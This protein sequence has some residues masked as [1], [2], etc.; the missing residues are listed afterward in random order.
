M[1]ILCQWDCQGLHHRS[2]QKKGV[3]NTGLAHRWLWDRL[4]IRLVKCFSHAAERQVLWESCRKC[5]HLPAWLTLCCTLKVIRSD[6]PCSLLCVSCP[7]VAPEWHA[8]VILNPADTVWFCWMYEGGEKVSVQ[9]V[10]GAQEVP[11]MSSFCF[12]VGGN[13]LDFDARKGNGRRQKGR[14]KTDGCVEMLYGH[15]SQSLNV[16]SLLYC[17]LF[18]GKQRCPGSFSSPS[19]RKIAGL[20]TPKHGRRILAPLPKSLLCKA[21]LI[22]V[23]RASGRECSPRQ[24]EWGEQ[25]TACHVQLADHSSLWCRVMDFEGKQK[26]SQ[27]GKGK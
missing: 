9:H 18:K 7:S 1:L 4:G 21:C 22:W 11:A 20:P 5:T 25:L 13:Y 8:E 3:N 19:A 12:G 23:R 27:E 15:F 10:H 26:Q 2:V 6:S 17:T 14:Q 16:S 24:R